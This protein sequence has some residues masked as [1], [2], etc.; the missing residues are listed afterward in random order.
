M[1]PQQT[2]LKLSHGPLATP[3]SSVAP[4]RRGL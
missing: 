1:A 3:L 2:K 4:P